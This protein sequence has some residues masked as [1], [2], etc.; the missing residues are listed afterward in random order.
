M[1]RTSQ[2][3]SDGDRV[4]DRR[5]GSTGTVRVFDLSA[6]DRREGCAEAEVKWDGSFVADELELAVDHGLDRA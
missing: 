1:V 3:Y 2:G 6:A 4:R 5:S